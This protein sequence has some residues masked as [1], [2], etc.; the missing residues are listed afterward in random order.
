METTRIA[1]VG[2]PFHHSTH[3]CVCGTI[4][5][6]WC[7]SNSKSI[8]STAVLPYIF[9][10]KIKL[11]HRER[12]IFFRCANC[13]PT[14]PIHHLFLPKYGE[15]SMKSCTTFPYSISHG[16]GCA[17]AQVW[18]ENTLQE[19]RPSPWVHRVLVQNPSWR[20]RYC[21]QTF[22]FGRGPSSCSFFSSLALLYT[23]L[24]PSTSTLSV[25]SLCLLLPSSFGSPSM[26]VM[27]TSILAKHFTDGFCTAPCGSHTIFHSLL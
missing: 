2:S 19:P 26:Q 13:L 7:T 15:K 27:N 16:P 12:T 22:S 6:T 1:Q 9:I 3:T 11:V 23:L 24:C 20:E 4:R 8:S 5:L 18:F 14:C 17:A 21:C 25:T 10:A